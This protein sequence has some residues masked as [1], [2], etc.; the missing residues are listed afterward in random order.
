MLSFVIKLPACISIVTD[1]EILYED[2]DNRIML[3]SQ[4]PVDIH[5]VHI[6]LQQQSKWTSFFFNESCLRTLVMQMSSN[7][8][9]LVSV[10][11]YALKP[12]E[13]QSLSNLINV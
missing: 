2:N 4:K 5:T 3:P 7:M 1:W 10:E 8:I 12:K 6:D 13:E 11:V 9:E